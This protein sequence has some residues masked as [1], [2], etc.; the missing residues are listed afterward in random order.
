MGPSKPPNKIEREWMAAVRSFGCIA[1]YIDGNFRHC[2]VH[3]I[4]VAGRRMGHLFTIGLC[5]PGHHQNGQ[6]FG[7]ISVHPWKARFEA[8]YGTQLELLGR[9]KVELGVY[10]KWETA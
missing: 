10:D 8:K 1:C 5:D 9:L 4:V 6:Q 7:M 3:H 2:A